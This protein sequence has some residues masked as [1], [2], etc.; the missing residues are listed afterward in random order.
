M[1]GVGGVFLY[2]KLTAQTREQA[3][4]EYMGYIEKN[5]YEKMYE[6]LDEGSKETISEEDFVTRNKNIYEGIEA[7]DIQLDIPEEQDKDQPLSYR[8]SMNTL[9]GEITYDTDT[10]FEKEEGKW[11]LVWKDSVI[12]PELGSEDKVRVSSVEAERGSIY[13]RN[14]VLLAGKGTVESVGLVPGKMNIQAEED[15]KALAEILGTTE[16]SIQ[17]KLDASWVQDDSFVP[18]KNMTQEQLLLTY[19]LW[20]LK[21]PKARMPNWRPT[22]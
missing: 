7:S 2:K 3:I 1:V 19:S 18:L 13:D 10:F 22:G 11:H 15:I 4:Q 5:E 21:S 16:D 14:D 17:A 9:A 8:V 6:L 12:F 20:G